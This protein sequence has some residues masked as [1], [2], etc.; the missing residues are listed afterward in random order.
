[1]TNISGMTFSPTLTHPWIISMT[2]VITTFDRVDPSFN[3]E[4]TIG[5]N[6]SRSIDFASA[7]TLII[8]RPIKG[9]IM[10]AL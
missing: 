2:I 8:T 9:T 6:D 5:Y 4:L 3:D 7:E 10:M 1:M